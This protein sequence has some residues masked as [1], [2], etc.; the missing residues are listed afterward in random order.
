MAPSALSSAFFNL[1]WLIVTLILTVA[2][3]GGKIFKMLTIVF[4][5][6][7]I[8]LTL[9]VIENFCKTMY[10][11]AG[12]K[13]E[14]AMVIAFLFKV[15]AALFGL[16]AGSGALY[17]AT[18]EIFNEVFSTT[19]LPLVLPED[20]KTLACLKLCRKKSQNKNDHGHHEDGL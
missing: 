19:V 11:S 5:L 3:F 14:E 6:V 13:D 10:E 8:T 15:I 20:L 18:A 17:I 9:V 12:V 7:D 1:I 2:L 16:A 4:M